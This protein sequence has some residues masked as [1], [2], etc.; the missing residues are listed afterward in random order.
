MSKGTYNMLNHEVLVLASGAPPQRFEG[1]ARLAGEC[2][3]HIRT[4]SR[5]MPPTDWTGDGVLVMLEDIPVLRRFISRVVKRGIPVVDLLED[6]PNTKV[7][8]VTGDNPEIGRM[9]ALHFNE[10]DFR[11][12]AFFSV[13]HNH[14]HD[15]RAAGFLEKW[16]GDTFEKWLWPDACKGSID[17]WKLMGEWLHEK[18][19]AAPKPLAVFAWND[20]DASHVLNACRKLDIKVPDEVAILGVDDNKVICEH[21]S[22]NLS[23]IAHDHQRVGY[24]AAATL[25]RLMSGGKLQRTV[26]R[27]KPQGIVTREST[28]TFAVNDPVL[29][30]AINYISRNLSHSF[31]AA[32]IAA[33]LGI[34]RIRLDRLFAAKLGHSAGVEIARWRIALA[35]KL[36][37][38][39]RDSLSEI[40]QKC[41]YCHASFFIRSFRRATGMTPT[42]WRRNPLQPSTGVTRE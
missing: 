41:G 23:S 36:L 3:W 16:E 32:Q 39:S 22:V 37:T 18:L 40:A 26:M 10:R 24:A 13:R 30:P 25:E 4:E 34:P 8:R 27:I 17:N 7:A 29:R 9:A 12:S 6:L 28:E 1:I 15:L 19:L 14:T 5:R 31:G 20:Y 33:A 35:K 11:H 42:A 38:T 2:G 21:Q